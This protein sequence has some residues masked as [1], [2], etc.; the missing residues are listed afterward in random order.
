M[1]FDIFLHVL[2]NSEV[3]D[4]TESE[5]KNVILTMTCSQ[6]MPEIKGEKRC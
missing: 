1:C 2:K 6:K 4:Q 3:Q 5:E